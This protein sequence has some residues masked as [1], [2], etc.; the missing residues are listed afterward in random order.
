MTAPASSGRAAIWGRAFLLAAEWGCTLAAVALWATERSPQ[1]LILLAAP[2]W[3]AAWIWRWL[4]LGTPT[5]ATGLDWPILLFLWTALVGLWAAPQLGAALARLDLFLGAV[6][7][8][9]LVANSP[10]P[11]RELFAYAL[12][13]VAVALAVY[14][15]SQHDWTSAPA[16]F[17]IIGR[18]GQLLNRHVPALHL[19]QPNANV[20]ANLLVLV[21]PVSTVQ[22]LAGLARW[23]RAQWPARLLVALSGLSALAILAGLVITESRASALALGGPLA[24]PCG[25]G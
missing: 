4:R 13:L 19:Y 11:G 23:R 12:G 5:R 15:A 24:W 16:K 10:K 18:V 21:L 25:G 8:Y 1:G 9:Y 6:G 2:L 3:V 7:L 20:V 17:A 14:F 22:T